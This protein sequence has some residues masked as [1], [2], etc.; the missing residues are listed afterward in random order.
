M[1]KMPRT[2][3]SN[4]CYFFSYIYTRTRVREVYGFEKISTDRVGGSTRT[5]ACQDRGLVEKATVA[6]AKA[7]E[8]TLVDFRFKKSEHSGYN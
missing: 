7:S 1:K 3:A 8:G 4:I 2:L 6:L 5:D